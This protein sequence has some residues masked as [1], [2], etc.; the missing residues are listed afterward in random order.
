MSKLPIGPV[1]IVVIPSSDVMF[2]PW[3]DQE[4]ASGW[5]P[6]VTMQETCANDPSSIISWPKLSG[7]RFGGSDQTKVISCERNIFKTAKTQCLSVMR[8]H[9]PLTFNSTVSMRIPA[10][11]DALQVY[12]PLC[13]WPTDG[14]TSM[15]PLP[16]IGVVTMPRSEVIFDPWND[17]AMER[18]SSPRRTIQ[19]T[20]A[21]SPSLITAAP[22]ER[23]NISGGSKMEREIEV[24]C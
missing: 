10:I 3:N 6:L 1:G 21:K 19:E 20:W 23:G 4:I 16:P 12:V 8:L 18:G 9:S 17:H 7:R 22:N 14:M 13:L 15:L 2:E 24:N 5:S 11:F